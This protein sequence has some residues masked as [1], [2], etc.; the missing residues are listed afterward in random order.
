ME[1]QEEKKRGGCL[2]AFLW[3]F[4]IF[5]SLGV[6]SDV[7][8]IFNSSNPISAPIKVITTLIAIVAVVSLIGIFM[9][10]KAGVIGYTLTTIVSG[11]IGIIN[12]N[13]SANGVV[14][15]S[16]VIICVVIW[17]VIVLAVLFI[18]IKPIYKFLQ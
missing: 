14:S 18:V 10:K 5:S 4:I 7:V 8:A 6:V 9:W 3:V 2:T 15:A 11:I 13:A 1:E 17:T 12:S 16:T